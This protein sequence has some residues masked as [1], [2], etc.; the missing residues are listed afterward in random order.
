MLITICYVYPT[1]PD[2]EISSQTIK[3][4]SSRVPTPLR[5][6][7]YVA[8]REA[9]FVDTNT[10]FNPDEAPSEPSD[11]R[12]PHHIPPAS[13]DST[14]P[15][16]PDHPLTQ[17]SPTSTPTRVS[18]HRRTARMTVLT[19]PAL[20]SGMS[21]RIAQAA[22]LPQSSFRKRYRSSY[23]TP[24]PSSSST[25]PIQKRYREDKVPGS[26][27][28]AAPEDQQQV[29]PVVDTTVREPLGLRYGALRCH[30][31]ALGEGSVPSTFETPPSLEWSSG[32]LP[33]SPSSLVVLSPIGSPVTTLASNISVDEDQF[34]E[35]RAQLEL[36]GSILCDHTQRLDALTPTLFDGYDRD[37]RELY[38]RPGAFRDE[39]F[40]QRPVLALEAWAGQTD[41]QRA[42]LWHVTYDIQR[43]NHDLKR[44]ITEE[45][46]RRLELTYR[47]ARMERRQ[48]SGGE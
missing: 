21:A 17:A 29:V 16:S 6:D 30:E 8:V 20:S 41:A 47:V 48:E 18:V 35:V 3:A 36:Y 32:S 38:T 12:T 26:E 7:P 44:Q 31:L 45:R 9:H 25:L 39:I 10:E 2:S 46:H 14:A 22:A 23:E 13:S 1:H 5:D 27:E 37:L 28:E 4:Q 33:V 19:Q 11:A 43:E 24:S 40:S 34:L 15:L 42:A